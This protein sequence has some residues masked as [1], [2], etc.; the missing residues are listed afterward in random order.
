MKFTIDLT[1]DHIH[2]T[3]RIESVGKI[4]FTFRIPK[5]QENS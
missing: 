4:E 1:T 5:K 3:G 2:C